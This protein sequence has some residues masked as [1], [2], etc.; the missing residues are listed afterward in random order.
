MRILLQETE[1]GAWMEN[2][3]VSYDY[4][5]Y[6]EIPDLPVDC[7]DGSCVSTDPLSV[8]PFLLYA[9]VFLVG[10]PGNAT[11]AWV[12][13]KEARRRVGATWFL[14]LAVA[15]LLCCL[16]LP[17][18]A[19]PMARGGHWPYG[20]LGCHTL[21][22]LI[23]LSMYASVLLLAALSADLCLL[24]LRPG[25]GAAGGRARRVQVACAVAWAVALLLTVPSAMY[26][27]LHQ[28]HFPPRL[29]CVVDYGGSAV[30]ESAVA[31]ARF[32]C[33][34]LGPLVVVASCHGA[35]LCRAAPHRWPLGVAVVLGFF[36]C[37]A[38]YQLLGL[39]I[40]VAAPHSRLLARALRAEP[41]VIGLALAH[42]CLNPV[43]FL[44]FGRTHLCRS[45]PAACRRALKESQSK[46]ESVVGKKSTSHDLVSEVE[47]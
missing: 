28:E 43:L 13:W 16:S 31:A 17:V 41:L 35:L 9:V 10:V 38:P 29:E 44:Y 21:S 39:V 45:L 1:P 46:D 3:S 34:F 7:V 33:G 42:S 30:V 26:H 22:S 12:T 2:T 18:L 27:R 24:A 19:V 37:W 11:M 32:V 47:V 14:H 23:L 8:A 15:D 4:G 6:D 20:A 5:H 40:T 36:V 25:W